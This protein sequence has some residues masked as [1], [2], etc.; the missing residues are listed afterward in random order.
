[1]RKKG[2]AL[3]YTALIILG[4]IFLI[5][6]IVFITYKLNP[7]IAIGLRKLNIWG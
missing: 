3:D 4:L 7:N 2:L 1:M 5:I 6:V